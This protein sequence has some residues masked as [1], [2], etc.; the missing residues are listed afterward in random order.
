MR[1]IDFTNGEYYN[2]YNRGVNKRK[3]FLNVA[4]MRRFFQSMEEF[5]TLEPI[6]SIYQNNYRKK[7]LSS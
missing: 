1:N 7:L 4:N 6:G 3:I 2:V 5:N